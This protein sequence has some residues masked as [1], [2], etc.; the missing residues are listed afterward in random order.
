MELI[1]AIDQGTQ[2]TR[3]CLYDANAVPVASAQLEFKQY[4]P[5]PGWCE[6]DPIEVWESIMVVV[7]QCMERAK[8]ALGTFEVKALGITNQRETTLVWDRATGKPLH[9]A[10]VWLDTR[11]REI[12]QRLSTQLGDKGYFRAVTG[13]PISTYFSGVKL[14]WLYENVPEVKAAVEAGTCMF[15][16]MDSWII[17]KLTGGVN[18]GEHVTDVTNASRTL[19]MDLASKQWHVPYLEIFGAKP[20][21]MPEIRSNSEIY[22]KVKEG[23]LAGVPICGCLGDQQA[24]MLGQ[25]CVTGEA[26]NTYG[27]GCFMLL[28][29]GNKIVPSSHG[30]LTTVAFQLGPEKAPQYA[31]EGAIAIAG[32]VISWLRDQLGVLNTADESEAV[33][34]L[35]PDTSGVYFVPAFSGLLAPHWRDDARGIIV[36]LTTYSNRSHLVRAAL[37]AICFQSREVLD[38]MRKDANLDAVKGL[39]VDGGATKNNLLLQIQADLLGVP[40]LRPDNQE[41]TA[42]GAALAAGLAVKFWTEAQIFRSGSAK[43]DEFSPQ[44]SRADREAR[45]AKW[46]KAVQRSLDLT[47]LVS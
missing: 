4:Y 40:V 10:I 42:L 16:T 23:L 18:G 19:M 39:K 41:T 37:E 35:V 13:L 17:Y 14:R 21:M 47:D 45:Y 11:T 31:L 26:K 9:N 15:G 36:G 8:E 34:R 2:S 20:A 38:A 33:A 27:T 28:N 32:A 43:R 3:F 22:G 46:R 5:H 12:A 44:V 1:G 30:L 7:A 29:T 24:A 6:H 25:R